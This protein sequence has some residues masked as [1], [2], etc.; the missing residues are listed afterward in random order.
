MTEM[1][2][3]GKDLII[4]VDPEDKEIGV[5]DKLLAHQ[6]GQLHRAFSVFI[7]NSKAELLLQQRAGTK[8]HSPGLWSNTCCSHPKPGEKT[9]D[10]C[11][12]RLKQ[13][14]GLKCKLEFGFSFTYKFHFSNGL[15]EHEFDH[16]YFGSTDD[17]PELNLNEVS[18]WKYI[19]LQALENEISLHPENYTPWLKICLPKIIGHYKHMTYEPDWKV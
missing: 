16:V 14:M 9:L 15:T 8:Y 4:L 2:S 12:R 10:A 17:L 11:N 6:S 7:F 3:E 19:R 13:E 18:N 5:S 1:N